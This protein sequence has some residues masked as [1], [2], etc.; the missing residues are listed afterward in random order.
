VLQLAGQVS[1]IAQ[2]VA[3][4]LRLIGPDRPWM[5]RIASACGGLQRCTPLNLTDLRPHDVLR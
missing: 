2:E 4:L 5:E 1:L 3:D